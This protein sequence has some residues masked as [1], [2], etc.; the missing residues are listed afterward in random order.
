[1]GEF[2]LKHSA[3]IASDQCKTIISIFW[4]KA[5][6]D[7]LSYRKILRLERHK[8]C[9]VTEKFWLFKKDNGV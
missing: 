8:Y 9:L 3:P 4:E 1:M 5:S 6:R 7:F 2:L